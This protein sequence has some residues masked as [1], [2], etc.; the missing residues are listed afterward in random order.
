MGFLDR[1]RGKKPEEEKVSPVQD[2]KQDK[3]TL[4]KICGD[5]RKAYEALRRTMLLDP[6]K[7]LATM[8]EAEERAKEFEKEEDMGRARTWY[9]TAGGLAI[10]NGDVEGVKKY[11]GKA[12]KINP[13][14]SYPILL[15]P[16]RAVAKAQEFYQEF[17]KE[18]ETPSR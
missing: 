16:E 8:E 9:E 17:L 18:E 15:M 11:F 4:E 14:I 1:L 7:A 13:D 2:Y 5:D 6:R 3:T 12:A 10:Y